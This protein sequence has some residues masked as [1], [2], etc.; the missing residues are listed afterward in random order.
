[1]Q[2]RG[3]TAEGYA[4]DGGLELDS[5]T[6]DQ[7]SIAEESTNALS[8]LAHQW[9]KL[10]LGDASSARMMC[11]TGTSPRCDVKHLEA[12][13]TRGGSDVGPATA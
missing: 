9:A 2:V 4:A 6:L 7:I 12:M 3:E 10:A 5:F 13:R 8:A 11:R 1:M